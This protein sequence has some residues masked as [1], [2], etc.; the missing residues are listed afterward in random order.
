MSCWDAI[1]IAAGPVMKK[2]E[3]M[4]VSPTARAIS[5]ALRLG[6]IEVLG[7]LEMFSRN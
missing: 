6:W 7:Q 5:D 3:Q 1:V 2:C 4:H